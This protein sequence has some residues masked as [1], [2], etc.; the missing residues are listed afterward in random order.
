MVMKDEREGKV[1]INSEGDIV[2]ARKIVRDAT[3]AM[4]FSVTDVTRVVTAASELARNAFRYAGS[5][6]MY[7]RMINASNGVGIELTFQD[8]GPGIPDIEQAME[9]GY[10]TGRGL[11]L[12]LPGAKRL[13]DDMTIES[14]AGQGT[15]VTVQKWRR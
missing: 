14:L 9:P 5:G 15:K 10:T 12:G 6:V 4:G 3:M 7:W 13:M 8:N 11:G 2:T 1:P